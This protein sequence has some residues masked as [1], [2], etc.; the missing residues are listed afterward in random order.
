MIAKNEERYRYG[1]DYEEDQSQRN[2]EGDNDTK[3]GG[4]MDLSEVIL[5]LVRVAL[6][7]DLLLW[8]MI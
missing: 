2:Q 8:M 5:L 3:I 6:G 4:L 7:L 1:H